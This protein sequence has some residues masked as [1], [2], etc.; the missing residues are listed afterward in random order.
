MFLFWYG[1]R[2][3]IHVVTPPQKAVEIDVLAW[4]WNWQFTHANGVTDSDL[5]VP[6]EHAGAPR[7]DEQGRAALVLR[8]GDAR[9]AGHRPAPL[10]VRVVQRDEAGHV[11][12]DVRR[13][14]RH[15]HAQ[16]AC[17][18]FPVNVIPC[19]IVLDSRSLTIAKPPGGWPC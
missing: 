8:A 16:M 1:W 5:H 17:L 2:S 14:L 12:A 4:R 10:H 15:G 9:E 3:Y 11:P 18:G 6:V 7:H 19:V 13:V